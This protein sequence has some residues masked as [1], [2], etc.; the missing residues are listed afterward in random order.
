QVDEKRLAE[1]KLPP[2]PPDMTMVLKTL[3]GLLH[4]LQM[5]VV[6]CCDQSEKL[7]K[8]PTALSEFTTAMMGWVDSVPNLVLAM[9][10]L[11]DDWQKL[12]ESFASFCDR[13]HGL[14]LEPLEGTQAVE[15]L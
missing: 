15:L 7:L 10:F 1:L 2:S 4:P 9:T 13:T 5:P 14:V 3:T 11:K 8:W 12:N 6:I